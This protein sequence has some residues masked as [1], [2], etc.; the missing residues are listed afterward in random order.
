[1]KKILCAAAA[2]TVATF[3]GH[4]HAGTASG[5][6]AVSATVLSSCLVT[7]TPLAFGNYNGTSTTDTTGSA[8]VTLICAGTSTA[9]IE[10]NYGLSPVGT[11]RYM[12]GPLTTDKLAYGLFKPV[13]AAAGAV[14]GTLTVPFGTTALG[15]SLPVINLSLS[16]QIFNVCGNI[17]TG[18]SAA[19]GAYADLVTVNVTF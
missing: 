8:T 11:T 17:P 19:L 4:T 15:A 10:M 12:T 7:S 18:Q 13:S 6:I 3:S 14:C 5:T 9:T 1:M 16:A 2:A